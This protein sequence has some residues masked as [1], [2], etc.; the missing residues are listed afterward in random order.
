MGGM[1]QSVQ[2]LFGWKDQEGDRI[3]GRLHILALVN[4]LGK[5]SFHH[6]PTSPWKT[7]LSAATPTLNLKSSLQYTWL[8]LTQNFQ[9][10]ATALETLEKNLLLNQSVEHAGFYADRTH[11]PLVTN[12]LTLRMET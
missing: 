3:P 9:D 10:V 11:A 8:H 6:P 7:L 12:A 1:I 4:M 2:P 5:D